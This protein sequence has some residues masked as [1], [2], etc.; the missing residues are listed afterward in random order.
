M[1]G[2]SKDPGGEMGEWG[3]ALTNPSMRPYWGGVQNFINQAGVNMAVGGVT[4]GVI[5]SAVGEFAAG[6]AE[7]Y[8]AGAGSAEAATTG[9]TYL[10]RNPETGQVMRTGRTNDL[11]RRQLEHARDPVL[12]NYDFETVHQTDSYAE[13]R[14]LEQ[15]LHDS[16]R[17]P[18]NKINPISPSNP[19]SPSYMDAA[20][21]F[22][23]F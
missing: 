23:N 16:Y 8:S 18:L 17:P 20:R 15:M 5:G 13:Q 21:T 7:G 14:G 11:A 6:F 3:Q 22:L 4:G 12:K 9:G 10:L 2:S 19:R 1:W